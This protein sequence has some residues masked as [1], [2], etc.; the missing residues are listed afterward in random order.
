M[1]CLSGRASRGSFRGHRGD[2]S[3]WACSP[4]RSGHCNWDH[5]P[6]RDL[7]HDRQGQTPTKSLSP[8]FVC[9]AG[10]QWSSRD[11]ATRQGLCGVVYPS[12]LCLC[13]TPSALVTK[14]R[15]QP[16]FSLPNA[17]SPHVASDSYSLLHSKTRGISD[18]RLLA[19]C[20]CSISWEQVVQ[21]SST[22]NV[23]KGTLRRRPCRFG[24]TQGKERLCTLR[25]GPKRAKRGVTIEKGVAK[26]VP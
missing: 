15:L 6:G 9:S 22:V 4:G 3:A 8:P 16:R 10:H 21:P 2:R 17:S 23:L 7:G 11:P 24:S 1:A 20:D 25:Q 13:S 19:K 26:S 12:L 18:E 14:V 5:L